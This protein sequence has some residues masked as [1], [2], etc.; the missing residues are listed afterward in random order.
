MKNKSKIAVISAVATALIGVSGTSSEAS[1]DSQTDFINKM[2]PSVKQATREYNLYASLQMAQAILESGWGTSTLSTEANNYFGVK[3][4]YKG[5]SVSMKTAEYD[6]NGNLYYVYADF[7][8]YPTP[9]ESMQGNASL[10]RNGVSWN[11][12]IY[13]GTWRENASSG[14]DATKGLIPSYATDPNYATKLKSLISTY[15]L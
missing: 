4:S 9:L 7:A 1:A 11:H 14:S 8:K 2:A 5:Q 3:G 6:S 15:N 12:A 13:S 10:L